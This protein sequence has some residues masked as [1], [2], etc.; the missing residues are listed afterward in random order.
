MLFVA[1]SNRGM[2]LLG[3]LLV[4]CLYCA[5]ACSQ[6]CAAGA[7]L[8]NC[9]CQLCPAGS[10]SAQRNNVSSCTSCADLAWKTSDAGST[11]RRPVSSTYLAASSSPC[12][13][14]PSVQVRTCMRPA[15]TLF[16]LYGNVTVR[17]GNRS[18]PS[19]AFVF[20]SLESV[21]LCSRVSSPYLCVHES[22]VRAFVFT[23]LKSVPLCL[24]VS[25][26]CLCVHESLVRAFVFTSLEP[27]H[28]ETQGPGRLHG[29]GWRGQ[30]TRNG[31][32]R[33]ALS[34]VRQPNAH[35]R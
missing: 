5:E 28:L 23:S 4:L 6:D 24:R 20:A 35:G 2:Q 12:Q 26:L 13:S 9:T 21:P 11:A 30:A 17:R 1:S 15:N 31:Q 3:L 14:R 10:Y 27:H 16:S 7:Y 32:R 18:L 29:R 25:S 34:S 19:R 33:G 8:S 22:R